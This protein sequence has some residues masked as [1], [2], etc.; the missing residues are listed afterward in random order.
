MKEPNR[1]EIT[2]EK[3]GWTWTYYGPGGT[4][5]AKSVRAY[6]SRHGAIG[7]LVVCRKG[8]AS[9]KTVAVNSAEVSDA[10]F[11]I[12]GTRTLPDDIT[13]LPSVVTD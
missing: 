10:P 5:I 1:I 3:S 4:A 7:G 6:S 2:Q 12:D 13:H 8:I 11:N 9:A